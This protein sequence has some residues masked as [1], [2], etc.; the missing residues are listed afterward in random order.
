MSSIQ[1][2]DGKIVGDYL[3]P[4]IVAEVNTSHFGKVDTALQMIDYLKEMDCDCVKFQ[5]WSANTLY[6]QTFYEKN[7]S[8]KRFV[9]KLSFSDEQ[10]REVAKYCREKRISFASTPY[11]REE[12]D[13]LVQQAEVPFLKVASMDLVNY[14]YLDYIGRIG[15]PIV[16]STG[17]ADIEEIEKAVET[18]VG[19]GNTKI[20]L[21]HCI[22]IYPAGV[23]ILN[24][25]NIV[26]LRRNFS[27]FPIGYSDHSLGT[28]MATSAVALGACL[29]EKHFTLDRSKIGMDNQMATEPN[30][31]AQ[32]IHQCRNVQLAL[33]K[34]ERNVQAAEKAQRLVMRRSIV[35][36]NDLKAGDILSA[37]DL[38]VKRPG[39]GLP[40]ETMAK[41]VGKRI[42]RDISRDTLI[43][44]EDIES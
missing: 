17:M 24:L 2:L 8:A 12:A 14:P 15:V 38:D 36:V 35:A 11:S 10:L 26:G 33:G 31:F 29:I 41:I 44:S 40:P 20:V 4:Y 6:S 1:F 3:R 18:I 30:Q 16:L 25:H 39:T 43:F 19:A 32:L 13:F 34:E 23:E 42:C 37:E 7:P 5:S 9:R 27:S 22:S 28:E 21:L